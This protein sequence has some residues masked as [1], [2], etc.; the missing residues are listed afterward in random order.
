MKKQI[1]ENKN[2][3]KKNTKKEKEKIF[4]YGYCF[5]KIFIFFLIGCLL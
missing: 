5:K 3:E 2:S 1:K 4:A